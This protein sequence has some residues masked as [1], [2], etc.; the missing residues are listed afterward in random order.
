MLIIIPRA[1]KK[2]AK[3][4]MIKETRRESTRYTGKYLTKKK[5]GMKKF[6]NKIQIFLNLHWGYIPINPH[7]VENIVK[8]KMHLIHLTYH[9]S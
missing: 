9:T 4:Y 3:K 8:S 7:Q 1:T 2:I 5:A 6:R